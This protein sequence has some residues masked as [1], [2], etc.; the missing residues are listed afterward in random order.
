RMLSTPSS[1]P[2]TPAG[3]F[4]PLMGS[5][6]FIPVL[7][8]TWPSF[9]YTCLSKNN[10]DAAAPDPADLAPKCF[11]NLLSNQLSSFVS[12]VS[13]SAQSLRDLVAPSPRPAE[14]PSPLPVAPSPANGFKMPEILPVPIPAPKPTQKNTLQQVQL[15]QQQPEMQLSA[16]WM[17]DLDDGWDNDGR[18]VEIIPSPWQQRCQGSEDYLYEAMD[19]DVESELEGVMSDPKES[20]D[21][22]PTDETATWKMR[23]LLEALRAGAPAPANFYEPVDSV[24]SGLYAISEE[25]SGGA[26]DEGAEVA[27][28][29]R[30]ARVGRGCGGKK[31]HAF[32]AA[33]LRLTREEMDAYAVREEDKEEKKSD[34][35]KKRGGR[36]GKG[37]R[38]WYYHKSA[39]QAAK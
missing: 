19:S 32:E 38:R 6:H 23:F 9:D 24:V 20:F 18:D 10:N 25:S 4:S 37:N 8:Q 7:Q 2:H 26:S 33:A 11:D 27:P 39:T 29:K 34:R 22:L 3:F 31:S 13:S 21:D 5:A 12:M 14:A 1:G 16:S 17:L 30:Q 35:K 36:G 15:Q 28:P